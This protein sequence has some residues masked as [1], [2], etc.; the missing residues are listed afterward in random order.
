MY[1]DAWLGSWING[2]FRVAKMHRMGV[3]GPTMVFF[4]S[5]SGSHREHS[6]FLY[7][8]TFFEIGRLR[9]PI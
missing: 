9:R 1:A 8:A 4:A 3:S 7:F 6:D 5:F 2:W